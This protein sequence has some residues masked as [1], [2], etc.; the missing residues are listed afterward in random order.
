ME[1]TKTLVYFKQ[2]PVKIKTCSKLKVKF[3]L[4]SILQHANKCHFLAILLIAMLCTLLDFALTAV[5]AK[6]WSE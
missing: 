6:S 5:I 3:S 2:L 1:K 4:V